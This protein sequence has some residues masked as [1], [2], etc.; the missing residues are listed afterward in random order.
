MILFLVGSVVVS[1]DVA[2]LMQKPPLLSQ[3]RNTPSK[4]DFFAARKFGLYLE[5]L[6]KKFAKQ[7]PY[8][9]VTIRTYSPSQISPLIP[10]R[11]A[12]GGKGV[13]RLTVNAVNRLCSI[14]CSSSSGESD[15]LMEDRSA[16]VALA[17]RPT[18]NF[19]RGGRELK[20]P[21]TLGTSYFLMY[22][23]IQILHMMPENFP[24][25]LSSK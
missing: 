19:C 16:S 6:Q 3:V 2:C 24:T 14:S 25:R 4:R 13:W 11:V 18:P 20:S 12:R 22:K 15:T 10:V 23:S 8:I 21:R 17:A 9:A 5:N 7:T 1:R